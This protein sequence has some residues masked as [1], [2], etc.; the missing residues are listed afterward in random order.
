[1]TPFSAARQ[2]CVSEKLPRR[3]N[4][5]VSRQSA[6][7]EGPPS[8]PAYTDRRQQER[9]EFR[10]SKTRSGKSKRR[11][12]RKRGAPLAPRF[13]RLA[14]LNLGARARL[15]ISLTLPN[16]PVTPRP[17]RGAP[18]AAT[19]RPMRSQC[20]ATR[21]DAVTMPFA[22]GYFSH[23]MLAAE[24]ASLRRSHLGRKFPAKNV[25]E[26]FVA[27]NLQRIGSSR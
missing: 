18:R 27:N 13:A 24:R 1:M 25:D 26:F 17:R 2:F 4:P 9:T 23:E 7:P 12:N 10:F 15:P 11:R 16:A 19:R 3:M 22:I 5:R 20:L 14:P 8:R 21:L 6:P